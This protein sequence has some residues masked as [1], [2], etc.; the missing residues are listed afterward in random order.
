MSME[1]NAHTIA[2]AAGRIGVKP[3]E[4]AAFLRRGSAVAYGPADVLF[5][6]STP[7]EWL[8]LVMEGEVDL[9]HGQQG[10]DV[11]IG[12]AQSGAVIGEGAMLDDTTHS[13]SAI[14]HQGAKVWQISREQL[15]RVRAEHPQVF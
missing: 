8:G 11:L 5:R 13:T 2:E 4:L 7:R 6:Q 3:E 12:V 10:K 9:L 15:E 1:L 14:T